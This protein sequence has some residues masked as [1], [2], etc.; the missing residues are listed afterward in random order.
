VSPRLASLL[1]LRRPGL[2]E[3]GIYRISG[4][5]SAIEGLKVAFSKQPADTIDL[6]QGD[7]SDVHTIAGAIKQ[8]FR[9]LPEP[10]VP[11]AF[12]NALIDAERIEDHEE[13]LYAIRDIIWEF[14]KPHFDVL[15]RV[16]EHLARV[17]EEGERNLMAPH[18]IGLVFGT[19]LL[20]PPPGPASVAQSFGNIGR[21][22]HIV[23]LIITTHDWLFEPEPE[24]EPEAELEGE[25]TIVEAKP[26]GLPPVLDVDE[27]Q[28]ESSTDEAGA[29]ST[30]AT[31]AVTPSVETDASPEFAFTAGSASQSSAALSSAPS[32]SADRLE[33]LATSSPPVHDA[34][35][36]EM[37]KLFAQRRPGGAREGAAGREDSIYLDATEGAQ[38]WPMTPPHRR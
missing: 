17:V 4:A 2:L 11:F 23:K 6:A 5:K 21:A 7:F 3:Q 30:F 24:P 26:A 35:A 15:R 13:R 37:A 1:T 32:E 12:Y 25:S 34:S 22:A 36:P 18:N 14:P 29:T 16:S 19:S 38:L 33:T 28:H 9:D 31:P 27:G 8:W 10:A 20:N